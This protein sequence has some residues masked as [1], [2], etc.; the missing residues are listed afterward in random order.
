MY[1]FVILLNGT[2]P[3]VMFLSVCCM[4][5]VISYLVHSLSIILFFLLHGFF[6]VLFSEK[7]KIETANEV[8]EKRMIWSPRLLVVARAFT[9]IV[10]ELEMVIEM[11]FCQWP[12]TA[13]RISLI[14]YCTRIY[15]YRIRQLERIYPDVLIVITYVVLYDTRTI[16]KAHIYGYTEHFMAKWFLFVTNKFYDCIYFVCFFFFPIFCFVLFCFPFSYFVLRLFIICFAA[17]NYLLEHLSTIIQLVIV[18]LCIFPVGVLQ[19][20]FYSI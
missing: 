5:N 18:I 16:Q 15:S 4:L 7:K 11:D 19:F 17:W 20:I 2:I 13:H 14:L 8:K 9:F 3:C 6:F 10:F 12:V 1:T